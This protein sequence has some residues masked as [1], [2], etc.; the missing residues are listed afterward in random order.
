MAENIREVIARMKSNQQNSQVSQNKSAPAPKPI[1]VEE[2]AEIQDE[3]DDYLDEDEEEVTPKSVKV[4]EKAVEK[5]D[6]NAVAEQ[7]IA[8][9]IEMLQ[10]NGRFRA[11][12]LHQLQEIN[13]A[14][15]VIAGTLVDLTKND[16]A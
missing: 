12:L 10:N 6:L 8:L 11:E 5:Q 16:K 13:K 3:E 9:E 2:V 14:L 4:E 7:Q 1:K 15:V